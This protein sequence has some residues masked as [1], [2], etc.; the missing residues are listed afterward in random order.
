[1][2]K[3]RPVGVDTRISVFADVNYQLL[4]NTMVCVNNDAK[5]MAS[6]WLS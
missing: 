6:S 1:M 2:L 3:A 4:L 5:L